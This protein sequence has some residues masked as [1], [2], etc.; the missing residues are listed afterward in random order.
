MATR[1]L[2]FIWFL[3]L[4]GHLV[5]L[6]VTPNSPCSAK[7]IDDSTLDESD[8]N[9][10]TTTTDHIVCEDARLA[11]SKWKSCMT[12]LQNS[13]HSQ[14]DESDQKWFLC[15]LRQNEHGNASTD[16]GTTPDNLRYSFDYCVYGYPSGSG[17]GS[18]PCETST[19]CGALRTAM[20]YGRLGPDSSEFGYC[21]ADGGAATGRYYDACLNC[22]RA[23]GDANYLA[24]GESH[25]LCGGF[26]QNVGSLV[27]PY[28]ALVALQAG[29][30]QRPNTTDLLG[31]SDSVF[32][33]DVIEIIDPST[34]NKPTQDAVPFISTAAIA[35]IAAGAVALV[36]IAAAAAYV[37]CRRRRNRTN[38]GMEPRWG[39][40]SRKH[41]RQSSFSFRCRNI[42]ASPISPKFFRDLSPVDEQPPYGSLGQQMATASSGTVEG[43]QGR[44]YIESKQSLWRHPYETS[45]DGWGAQ[46]GGAAPSPPQPEAAVGQWNTFAFPEKKGRA[47]RAAMSIDT[48]LSAPPEAHKSP[49]QNVFEISHSRRPQ[50]TMQQ[51][52]P[53]SSPAD[54]VTG[55]PVATAN[56]PSRG[57]GGNKPKT[58][59]MS[60]QGSGYPKLQSPT[61]SSPVLRPGGP[62]TPPRDLDEAEPW[63][64]PPPP[65][66]PPPASSSPFSSRYSRKVSG[67]STSP[68]KAKRESGSPVESQQIQIVFPGPPG[69]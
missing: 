54:H 64:P 46:G 14:G 28:V 20:E 21:D 31:L 50:Q 5:A 29:C 16:S 6:Q 12:C 10:S 3:S 30:E 53:T 45:L 47:K 51:Q 26:L 8:P 4:L 60:S 25:R 2:C 66:G 15:K 19:A 63:F 32:S 1:S 62:T 40:T 65:P 11:G 68:R 43:H 49:K 57:G 48:G 24:N 56:S 17:S 9:S 39:K 27:I 67:G 42:L 69:R 18:N 23:G 41:K 55:S 36:A 34:M 44:Y 52:P 33:G 7:C 35:G 59:T 58:T 38:L 61:W 22:V 13:T 37:C